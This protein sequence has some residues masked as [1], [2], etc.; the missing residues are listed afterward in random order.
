MKYLFFIPLFLSI[1]SI[2]YYLLTI[3]AGVKFFQQKTPINSQFHPPV[4]ILK[5]LCGLDNDTYGNLASF[6]QQNY[7]EYQIVFAV[8]NS[9]DPCIEIVNK[10]LAEFPHLDL[11]L[12]ISDRAIGTNLKVSNLNNAL[13]KA[14]HNILIIADSD[15]RVKPD[16]LQTVIQPLQDEKN[17]VV[18]C[19]YRSISNHWISS[20]ESLARSTEFHPSVL[21]AQQLEGVKFAFGSTI[22]IRKQVLEKI[23]S[24]EAIADYLADD[25]LLGKLPTEIG[26]KTILSDYIVDHVLGESTI[27][28]SL[29]RQSRWDK[30]TKVSR[31][32]GYIGLIFTYGTVH[33]L[34]LLLLT[35]ASILGIIVLTITWVIRLL[36]AW[37]IGVK[38]INDDLAKKYL[39][40]V[41]I[42]DIISCCSWIYSFFSNQVEW[43]GKKFN[44]IKGGKLELIKT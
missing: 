11:E 44:L 19:L 20:L 9:D 13:T 8:Q 36:S 3:Y 38:L 31:L 10:L 42:R 6:C 22:V 16:Y 23:G 2:I 39:F 29:Q 34:I 32:G 17:G 26:Y 15:I 27:I 37:I 18:T 43:R 21:L 35:K 1:T 12:M 40:L 5:P 25:Y 30:C 4:T 24:F 41:P 33:S 28:E 14:K 7:H